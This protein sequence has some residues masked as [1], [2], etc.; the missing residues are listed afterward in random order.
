MFT[1]LVDTVLVALNNKCWKKGEESDFRLDEWY[2]PSVEYADDIVVLATSQKAL[3]QKDFGPH[4]RVQ[5]NRSRDSPCKKQTGA[6][7]TS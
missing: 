1:F 2:F 5:R 4:R 7:R 6:Q 3:E